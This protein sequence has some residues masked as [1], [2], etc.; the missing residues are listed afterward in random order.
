MSFSSRTM[1]EPDWD[2]ITN[3]KPTEFKNPE[4]MGY[5][6]MLW[7]DKLRTKANVPMTITS[8]YR[9]AAY[10]K[11]VGG[12]TDSAHVDIPCDAIDIGMRPRPSDPNWNFTRFQIVKTAI[13]MGCQRIGTYAN[14]SLHL[15]RTEHKRPAPRM[16]RVVKGH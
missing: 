1:R 9:S 6:F 16:W 8:S 13:E 15:D 7:L 14:G 4:K 2:E 3:F 5:E 11:S 12:A 10:N